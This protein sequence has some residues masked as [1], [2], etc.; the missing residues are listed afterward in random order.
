MG[1]NKIK[2]IGLT[3]GIATGKT[4]VKNILIKY[5]YKVIDADEI[6]REVVK[7]NKPAYK[8]IVDFFGK[9]VLN[10]ND[11]I[12]REKLGGIIFNK[13]DLRNKL[14]EIVHPRVYESIRNNIYKYIK[15]N[16]KVIF[17]DIPLLIEVRKRLEKEKIIFDEIWLIYLNKDEQ[18]K[19]L[20]N[21]DRY[22]FKEAMSRINAQIDIDEKIK[23]CDIVIDNSRDIEH[24]KR[25]LKVALS[26]NDF[27]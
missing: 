27:M 16:Q 25:Q 14:N 15:E 2:I 19:R 11:E 8:D 1:Q 21:R 7:K 3:G 5:G 24:T 20:M 26:K 12:N 18:I 6:S 4:T 17:I 9:D 10:S 13:K 22:T 23:Y